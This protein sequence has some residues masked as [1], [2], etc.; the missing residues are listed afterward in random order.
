MWPIERAS[1]LDSSP[2][3][4]AGNLLNPLLNP[5]SSA[6]KTMC[7]GNAPRQ[8]CIQHRPLVLHYPFHHWLQ[9]SGVAW[10]VKK[11]GR[12]SSG[13]YRVARL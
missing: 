10:F 12:K 3:E 13:S 2:E 8:H 11:V 6:L 4:P 7:P 9:H 1:S 5:A